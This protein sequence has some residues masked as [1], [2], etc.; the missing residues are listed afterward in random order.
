ME[1]DPGAPDHH[2]GSAPRRHPSDRGDGRDG[3]PHRARLEEDHDHEGGRARLLGEEAWDRGRC[4]RQVRSRRHDHGEG[5]RCRCRRRPHR[6][7]SRDRAGAA[8]VSGGGGARGA[9]R[10]FPQA[11][12]FA[13]RGSRAG[14]LGLGRHVAAVR[15]EQVRQHAQAVA[16]VRGRLAE[17]RH[18]PL[19]RLRMSVAAPVVVLANPSAGRGK[20]GRR[21][22]RIGDQLQR[23]GVDH[24]IRVSTSGEDLERRAREAADEGAKVVAVLGGDGSV[25][26]AANG[27]LGTGA[28][29]AVLPSGTADDFA[30]S[31]GVRK[32]E[33]AIRAIA[34]A[35]IVQIDVARVD[36]GATRRHYVAIAGCG[37]DS[38]VNEAA[39]AMRVNLGAT[40]TYVAA[41]VKTL[42][43]FSPAGFRIELDD[44]VIEGPHML[45]IVGNSISYGGGMK[46]TPDASIVDGWLD[47]CLLREMSK[48]A[49][50][51]AFPKVF[52]GTHVS[53]PAVRMARA[54]RV[55]IEA[56]RRVM[57]YA[58][59]ERVGPA[60]AVFEILPG[61]LPVI[62]GP[63]A[64]AVR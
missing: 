33:T 22:G 63:N 19:G 64:K 9:R 11:P 56:D 18:G 59:G 49:F 27:L 46:V 5:L 12:R 47:V 25:G 8:P 28:A 62:V 13:A 58:D 15:V 50:I 41:L 57:V 34:D 16:T 6:V 39:N 43:R 60:P 51:R 4:H 35:N 26:L 52:R 7:E 40:G 2:R 53:H 1:G 21:I 10:R 48:G 17:R 42:S 14:H 38:E 24:E 32:L 31:I 30:A 55:R 36:A 45:V 37:F 23:A 44:E 29:L 3:G 61:A 20:A 54:T